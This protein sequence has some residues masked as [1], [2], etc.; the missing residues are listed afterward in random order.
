MLSL[1]SIV[2]SW[3]LK[4]AVQGVAGTAQ[5]SRPVSWGP[6]PARGAT[7]MGPG[8]V[9]P[10]NVAGSPGCSW[11]TSCCSAPSASTPAHRRALP[12]GAMEYSLH[13]RQT[14]SCWVQTCAQTMPG[15]Y[16]QCLTTSQQ[17]R[18]GCSLVPKRTQLPES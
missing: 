14:E 13:R 18:S 1:G 7:R 6:T 3:R 15:W 16:G 11:A 9:G 12:R 4:R 17:M 10:P 2:S 5:G 8:L